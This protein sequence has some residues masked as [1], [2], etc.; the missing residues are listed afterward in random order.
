MKAT[1]QWKEDQMMQKNFYQDSIGTGA[2]IL[3]I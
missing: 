1:Y 3:S 2:S